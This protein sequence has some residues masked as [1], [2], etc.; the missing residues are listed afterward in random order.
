M[1]ITISPALTFTEQLRHY[2]KQRGFSVVRLA[3][4][5]GLAKATLD[6][7]QAGRTLPSAPELEALLSALELGSF[8]QRLLRRLVGVPRA[9]ATLSE[10]ER[11]PLTGGLVRA[12][13]LR[14]GLTQS[15]VAS[16][17]EIRQGTLAKWE[18]SDDWPEADKLSALCAVLGA[19]PQE[20]EAI[21]GGVFL[22]L[23]LPIDASRDD[24]QEQVEVLSDRISQ[25]PSDPLLD[26]AFFELESLLWL[27]GDRPATQE[28][29]WRVWCY[30]NNYLLMH[31]RYEETLTYANRMLA[32]S[33]DPSDPS[34]SYLQS[35]VIQKAK[36]LR[37]STNSWEGQK[38]R[39]KKSIVF[40]DAHQGRIADP[41]NK[42][43]YWMELVSLL[44]AEG[45]Y[46]EARTCLARS[47]AIPHHQCVRGAMGESALVTAQ[48]LTN[49]G[50]PREALS[51]LT[52]STLGRDDPSFSPLMEMR[53]HLYCASALAKLQD[54]SGALL[55]LDAV[56]EQMEA[57]GIF[58]MRASAEVLYFQLMH[59]P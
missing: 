53:L 47:N 8:D 31:H 9:I 30:H 37:G 40:L 54:T 18:K 55:E 17:L 59:L 11:P 48:N 25:R 16:K 41:E 45:A 1:D 20:V 24:L 21:L 36:A 26:L 2:R 50:S 56:F 14:R 46:D 27:H 28:L 57:T 44:I 19:K 32:I 4:Q 49:L 35:A 13:R 22:P 38:A 58:T 42:A 39:W 33:Y 6:N 23:P 29:Q 52:S 34:T 7:W 10:E 12:M 5:A 43:W 3:E 15:E 51:L